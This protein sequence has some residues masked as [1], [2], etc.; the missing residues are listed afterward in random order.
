VHTTP[1]AQLGTCVQETHWSAAPLLPW[2]RYR[3][4]RHSLH[5]E[6]CA[7]VQVSCDMQPA[8]VVHAVQ[9]S[10]R[11]LVSSKVPAPH[12]AHCESKAVV[13]VMAL[14]QLA[15]AVH[16]VQ[17]NGSEGQKPS[18]HLPQLVS[19]AVVQARAAQSSMGGAGAT[20]ASQPLGVS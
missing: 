20:H 19:L 16:A 13:Q 4:G 10:A 1:L 14:V 11:A 12:C 9:T 8:T 2:T 18:A 17:V 5:C 3:P 15:T 6:F 7:V